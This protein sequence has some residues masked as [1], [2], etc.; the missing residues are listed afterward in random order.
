MTAFFDSFEQNSEKLDSLFENCADI[1]SRDVNLEYMSKRRGRIYY[2]ESAVREV[3]IRKVVYGLTDVEKLETLEDIINAVLTGN[4][5]LLIDGE[6]YALKVRTSGYP[7]LGVQEAKDEQVL[8]GSNEGFSDSYKTN[9]SLVRKRIRSGELKVEEMT[10]GVRTNTGVAILYM[11]TI[12]RKEVLK[13]V[14][15]RLKNFEIDGVLDSGVIEQLTMDNEYSPFPQYMTTQRPDKAALALLNGH[16]IILVNNSPIALILPVNFASFFKAADD[17][18]NRWEIVS[19]VRFLRYIAAFFAMSLPAL[20]IAVLNFHAEILPFDL[21][22]KFIEARDGIPYPIFVEVILMEIA[23]ELIREAGVRIPGPMGNTIGIVGGLIVGS[24]A[25][26]AS[27]AS[28]VI[29]IVVALTALCS[30]TIPNDEFS[31]AFRL[32]K[33]FLIILSG[34]AGLFGYVVGLLTIFIHLS[35]LKSYGFPYLGPVAAGELNNKNDQ[36][37]MI[38]RMP[39]MHMKRRPIFARSSNRTKMAVGSDARKQKGQ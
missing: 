10:T 39:Y 34:I 30:F 6:S 7:E 32:I 23:F 11:D 26:D 2:V 4:A 12:V 35:G 31:S 22:L 36:K 27:L 19:F 8:R 14:R 33:Y 21:A 18:Y 37:D 20:Y 13:E 1:K 25:V 16:V 28:P 9:E 24:A 5:A 29:V 17:Y 15:R 38:F 3:T